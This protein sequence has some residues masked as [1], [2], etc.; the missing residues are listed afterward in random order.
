MDSNDRPKVGLGVIILKEEKVL[1][2]KRRNSHGDGTWS[3]PGGHLEKYETFK[4][5]AER[6]TK[7]ETGLD[8][9]IIDNRPVAITND[10]FYNENK[11][12]ITIYMK[13]KYVSGIPKISEIEENKIEKIDWFNWNNL[14]EPLF[15]PI[16]NLIK[17]GYNPF[18]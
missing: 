10:F 4:Q 18:N 13:A 12:Y 17:Q 6:E 5:C 8:I 1:M 14:P 3:F 16:Q 15:L 2:Q 9:N 11:H 7:E